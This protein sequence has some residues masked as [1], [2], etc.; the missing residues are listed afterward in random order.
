MTDD[1]YPREVRLAVGI[2]GTGVGLAV[3]G[4][5]CVNS[6]AGGHVVVSLAVAALGS[7]LTA[8]SAVMAMRNLNPPRYRRGFGDNVG[9]R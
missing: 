9:R 2:I 3:I 7:A 5:A 6:I 8:A 4:L 1:F